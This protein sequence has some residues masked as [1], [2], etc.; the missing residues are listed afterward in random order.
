[1]ELMKEIEKN[2][3]NENISLEKRIWFYINALPKYYNQAIT[4]LLREEYQDYTLV[5]PYK[6]TLNYDDKGKLYIDARGTDDSYRLLIYSEDSIKNSSEKEFGK[7]VTD[8]E[9]YKLACNFKF[10]SKEILEYAE[11]KSR[12]IPIRERIESYTKKQKILID[13][14]DERL[15]ELSYT[16]LDVPSAS[17]KEELE[18]SKNIILGNIKNIYYNKKDNEMVYISYKEPESD[19]TTRERKN[20]ERRVYNERINDIIPFE[21]RKEVIN[22]MDIKYTCSAYSE[23]EGEI[24]NYGYLIENQE[25]LPILIIEP[26]SGLGYTKVVYLNEDYELSAEEFGEVCKY[27]MELTNNE[28]Y[29][30]SGTVRFNHT[31]KEEFINNLKYISGINNKIDSY[32][33]MARI[34]AAYKTRKGN[35][36]YSFIPGIVKKKVI[37]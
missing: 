7:K 8:K 33:K 1:M 19:I 18:Q 34:A 28:F 9:V 30:C 25:N 10:L 15:K 37:E 21:E 6:Y 13:R 20:N 4:Y 27:Y 31:S 22:K 23:N 5:A 11:E 14:T 26:V 24:N 3:A 12:N 17:N 16:I 32:E 35:K 2:I 36:F 29:N